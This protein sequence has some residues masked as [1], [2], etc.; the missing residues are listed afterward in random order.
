MPVGKITLGRNV[1]CP[2]RKKGGCIFCAP[3][4]FRPYYLSE[5]DPLSV[6]IKKGKQFLKSRNFKRYFAYF[7]Q[8]TTT[9]SPCQEI[10][11]DFTQALVDSA[12]IG[13]IVSTR[14]DYLEDRVLDELAALAQRS[15]PPKEIILELGLQS[16]HDRTLKL[17][18]RNHSYNDFVRAADRVNRHDFLQLG[19]HVILGLPG[20]D[21]ADMQHTIA[22]IG[23]H[24]VQHLKIHHLQ[25]IKDTQLQVMYEQGAVKTFTVTQYIKLL[26]NLL[27]GVPEDVVIHRLWS[28]SGPDLLIAPRWGMTNH[29]LSA[30]IRDVMAEEGC[31]QGKHL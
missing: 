6:Q 18:N 2:N 15:S 10:M 27:N 29:K 11:A 1:P 17:I 13:L 16:A 21:L 5:N 4:S 19:A 8:E 3:D 28:I 30:L 9:A 14:P 25:V 24:G 23:V 26:G 7:Q 20:E 31:W 22:E 12:C